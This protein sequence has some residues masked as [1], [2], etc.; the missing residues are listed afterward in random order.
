MLQDAVPFGHIRRLKSSA[1]AVPRSTVQRHR[2]AAINT[3]TGNEKAEP[4]G[5]PKRPQPVPHFISDGGVSLLFGLLL[6]AAGA[7]A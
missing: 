6:V 3:I 1:C 7:A 2:G 5:E 4:A